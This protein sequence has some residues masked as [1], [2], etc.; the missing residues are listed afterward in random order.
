[1]GRTTT[2]LNLAV[3]QAELGHHVLPVDLDPQGGIGHSLAWKDGALVGLADL[4]AD[5]IPLRQAVIATRGLK[6]PSSYFP[7]DPQPVTR[8][9]Y[10]PHTEHLLKA[11]IRSDES[12]VPALSG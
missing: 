3:A 6:N 7:S 5:R 4:L 9:N 1:M 8:T 10:R 11:A 12:S 2:A